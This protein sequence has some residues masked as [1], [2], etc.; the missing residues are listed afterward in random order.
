MQTRVLSVNVGEKRTQPKGNGLETTGI[1]KLPVDG[2]VQVGPLGIPGDF[3]GSLKHHGGPDQAL[4]LYG[5]LD[6]R[7]WSAELGH[8]LYPGTFGENLTLADFESARCNVGD[9]LVIGSVVLEFTA[10]R[11]PCSTLSRRMGDPQFIRLYRRAERPGVYCRVIREGTV[12]A[13]DLAQLIP[14]QA[15]TVS[16]L[17]IFLEHYASDRDPVLLRRM[18]AAPIA[19]RTRAEAEKALEALRT[20]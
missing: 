14:Y 9:R 12:K 5:D 10:P 13:G 7:W 1:Y 8:E 3:I 15:P 6:Y 17:E 11:T 16:M 18:L 4:Y 2:P 20:G 19:A